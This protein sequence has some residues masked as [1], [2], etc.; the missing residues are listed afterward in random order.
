MSGFKKRLEYILKHNT[1][2]Q[3]IYK[4]VMSWAF[5][6][7]GLFTK[8]DNKL[9]LFNSFGGRKFNDSPRVLF[10]AMLNDPR[11][12][13]YQ[14]VWAFEKPDEFN[15]PGAKCIKICPFGFVLR[16]CGQQHRP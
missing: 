7:I 16:Q 5:R 14:F 15:I 6:C 13:G 12:V 10:N 2:I 11:F 9:I 8:I 1:G 4:H 3:F